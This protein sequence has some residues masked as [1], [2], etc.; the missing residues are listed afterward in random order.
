MDI[1]GSLS[2]VEVDT[3]PRMRRTVDFIRAEGGACLGRVMQAAITML[4]ELP[5]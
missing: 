2:L 5:G 1:G 4:A 3:L